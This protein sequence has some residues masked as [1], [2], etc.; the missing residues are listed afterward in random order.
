MFSRRFYSDNGRARPR[1]HLSEQARNTIYYRNQLIQ[2]IYRSRE[3]Y[4]N[5]V[6]NM[7]RE[8]EML[9]FSMPWLSR[10]DFQPNVRNPVMS[11]NQN[12]NDAANASTT[13]DTNANVDVNANASGPGPAP[14][15]G[16]NI[17]RSGA[18][19]G[20]YGGVQRSNVQH[21]NPFHGVFMDITNMF[22]N[23]ANSPVANRGLSNEQIC[24]AVRDC[25]YGELDASVRE[26]YTTCPITLDQF[27]ESMEVGVLRACG[28]VFRREAIVNWLST[29]STCPSCRR[30]L[31]EPVF[32]SLNTQAANNGGAGGGASGWGVNIPTGVSSTHPSI[33]THIMN[34]T[35]RH[36]TGPDGQIGLEFD[37]IIGVPTSVGDESEHQR[38]IVSIL[39]QMFNLPSITGE[40]LQIRSEEREREDA[41][42]RL[43]AL[44]EIARHYA[45]DSDHEG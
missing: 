17:V 29:R 45:S 12:N 28:H 22:L 40:G 37:G 14:N 42:T 2:N 3:V 23:S 27:E 32:N 10:D 7:R 5:I 20:F 21:S 41:S 8:N 4:D 19:S 18:N 26:S 15:V 43:N 38:H 39:D 9:F 31:S 1:Y 24:V 30:D 36:T 44:N 11:E 6:E 33:G 25:L 35:V 16:S 13:A 34:P